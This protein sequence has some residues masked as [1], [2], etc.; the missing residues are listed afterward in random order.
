VTGACLGIRAC[1]V[2]VAMGLW[3]C[4]TWA[5][6]MEE[7]DYIRVEPPV[8]AAGDAIEVIEF[9]YYGC[10]ACYR[11]EPM[12][13]AWMEKLPGDVIFRRIPALRRQA[14]IPLTRLYFS[15]EA[16]GVLGRLH[17]RVYRGI[18]EQGLNLGNSSEL[19]PWADGH[20]VDR[21]LLAATLDSDR[22]SRDV[23]RARDLTI[24][25]GVRSTPSIVVDGRF[26]TNA[27][28]LGDVEALLPTVDALIEKA[29]TSDRPR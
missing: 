26:L 17:G 16:L 1:V 10:P 23:Q 24:T 22:T 21:E 29:R 11:L 5:E 8:P 3:A 6:P 9:F 4:A 25:Y 28:M 20:G 15:L 19:L 18:H 12:L 7:V 14:W 13:E 27:E 2:A